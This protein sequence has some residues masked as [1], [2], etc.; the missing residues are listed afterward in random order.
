MSA[1]YDPNNYE[2]NKM[3]ITEQEET[4]GGFI[5]WMLYVTLATIFV[6][7]FLLLAQT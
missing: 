7:M 1:D 2:R 4:F 5:R 6:L 3:D